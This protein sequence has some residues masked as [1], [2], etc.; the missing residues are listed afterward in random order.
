MHIVNNKQQGADTTTTH[1]MSNNI[2]Y[3]NDIGRSA[4][5][6]MVD[7]DEQIYPLIS[8]QIAVKKAY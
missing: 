5:I 4:K 8:F 3:K 1:T 7:L 2:N 6:N